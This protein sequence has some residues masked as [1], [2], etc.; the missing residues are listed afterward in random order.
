MIV[1]FD[2]PAMPTPD[3]P[4]IEVY[5][6]S[7]CTPCRL[8]LP[9]LAQLAEKETAPIVIVLLTDEKKA[10][11]QIAAVSSKLETLAVLPSG[12]DSHALLRVAG[13]AE[14]ILPYARSLHSNGQTCNSWRGLLSVDRVRMMLRACK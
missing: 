10:R 4:L 3:G 5:Y 6:A 1:M 11:E 8:E 9:I 12:P 2:F 13:D 14:G 7:N